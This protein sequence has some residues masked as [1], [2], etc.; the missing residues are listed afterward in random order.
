M[1]DFNSFRAMLS[2]TGEDP[3]DSEERLRS[4]RRHRQEEV[5]ASILKQ[6]FGNAKLTLFKMVHDYSLRFL[7]FR[8]NEREYLDNLTYTQRRC[9][10]ELG[11]RMA[12]RGLL[13]ERD[14]VWFLGVEENFSVLYGTHNQQLAQAKIVGRKK[15]FMRFLK[16]EADLPNYLNPDGTA[17]LPGELIGA[18]AETT[19]LSD[20]V[21]AGAG[22]SQGLITG[23][24]RVIRNLDEIGSLIRGDILICNSTDPGWTPVFLI[25]SGLV[26]ES[27]GMLSH[28]ACLSREY[29]L[30]AVTCPDAMRKIE[31]GTMISLDGSRGLV[32]LDALEETS[33]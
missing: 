27:G 9:F 4:A 30:P 28:G 3:R 32:Y 10:L 29:G 14:D 24:A 22:M 7:A 16:R 11:R 1:I 5:H 17:A 31:D 12:E 8:D 19:G 15:N 25:I 20:R 18:V 21:L 23:R 2:S 33:A 6:P 13:A 26:L